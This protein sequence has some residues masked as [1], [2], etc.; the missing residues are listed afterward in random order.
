MSRPL[1]TFDQLK[2]TLYTVRSSANHNSPNVHLVTIKLNVVYFRK[3]LQGT[4]FGASLSEPRITR[5]TGSGV[6]LYIYLCVILHSNEVMRML[7]TNN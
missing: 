4:L 6:Y 7:D 3:L 5:E 1:Q 2:F